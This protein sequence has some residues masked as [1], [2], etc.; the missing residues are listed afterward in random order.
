MNEYKIQIIE[1]LIIFVLYL[2]AFFILG[3][4]LPVGVYFFDSLAWLFFLTLALVYFVHTI[5]MASVVLRRPRSF[6]DIS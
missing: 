3:A 5:H 4:L 6:W 1:T 2:I